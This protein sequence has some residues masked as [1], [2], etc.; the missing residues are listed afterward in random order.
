MIATLINAAL[1]LLG[2]LLGVAFKHL[3][4]E[5][6]SKVLTS[7][8]ALCVLGIGIN[9]MI[10][11]NDT[12][13]VILCMVTGT[14]IGEAV[15]IERR[16]EDAGN[17]LRRTL[18]RNQQ[19]SSFTEGFVTASL[20][21]CVGAMAITGSIEAGLNHNYSILISKGVLDGVSA[22]SFTAAMGMGA[23]FSVFP[24]LIYQGAI[25]LL[26]SVVGPYLGEAVI[27][28]MSAVGGTIIVALGINMLELG[29]DKLKAG[30]M[31]PAIFLPIVYLPFAEWLKN[32]QL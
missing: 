4:S 31:L 1:I 26:A 9:G 12:L 5:R 24:L 11:T 7:A 17:L 22:I 13:C 14:L 25:T 20:L 27:T 28:E 6:L 8:L 23:A 2:S 3:I 21:Y 32:I 30:N 10:G 16:L 15:D 18:V 19:T 29:K